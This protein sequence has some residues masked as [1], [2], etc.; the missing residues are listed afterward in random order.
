MAGIGFE[1]KKMFDKKGILAT[2][3]AYGYAGIVCIG[4]MILG[5]I[6]LLG[7]RYMAGVGGAS[8]EEKELINCMVTY[9]LLASMVLTN[10]FA[11]VTTRYTADQLYMDKKEK[12]LP[13]FWGSASIMLVIGGIL[14]GI[15][16]AFS[17]VALKYQVLCL[18][19]FCELIVVW[20]Q[21]NYLT[22]IKDYKGVL[23]TFA[24]ALVVSFVAGYVMILLHVEVI[25][26]MM[27]TVCI[28]YGVM[29]VWYYLLLVRYFPK[30]EGNTFEFLKWF[31]RYPELGI[32]GFNLSVGLF[33]HLVI[34][35]SS[36][37]KKQIAGLFYGA[38]TYDIAALIAFLSILITTIN[39]VTSVEVNF[40]PKYRTY[41]SLFNDGGTLK[42]IEQAEREMVSTLGQELMYTFTKQFFT[43]VVFIIGGTMLLPYLP[44][45][46]SEDMLGIYRVL[47]IAYAFYAIGNATMLI[48]LYFADGKGALISSTS[49]MAVSLVATWITRTMSIKCYGI[50]FLLGGLTF[51]AV[52]LVL[53]F[54]YLD[55]IMY[56]VLCNQPLVADEKQGKFTKLSNWAYTKELKRRYKIEKR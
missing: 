8:E 6:L 46:M 47:C 38:P 15:F 30:G 32:I 44:L 28:A 53:L 10:L 33:G 11:L 29:M 34:M 48:Q 16:L 17:G 7:V 25:T 39:F 9:T 12:I 3:K 41:F 19:I 22:A 50:G 56:H 45:G 23:L 31:D 35:W 52:A 20:T 21:I 26:A 13:S 40:Y 43:T 54:R 4:P 36:P 27:M 14:Y 18:S 24:A 55:R 51:A 5:I 49:F 42:D 2:L 37:V 1:L